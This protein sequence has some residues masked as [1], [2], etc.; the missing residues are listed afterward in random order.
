[1]KLDDVTRAMHALAMHGSVEGRRRFNMQGRVYPTNY[2][3]ARS[4]RERPASKSHYEV[5]QGI[6]DYLAAAAFRSRQ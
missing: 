2:F 6:R 5:F 1:M 4:S 3:A